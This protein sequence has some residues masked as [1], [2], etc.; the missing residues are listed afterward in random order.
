M[1][2]EVYM[3]SCLISCYN[4]HL[5]LRTIS[6]VLTEWLPYEGL[7]VGSEGVQ[8]EGSH[9]GRALL[10]GFLHCRQLPMTQALS[11]QEILIGLENSL[12]SII[13]RCHPI[14]ARKDLDYSAK[15]SVTYYDVLLP[16]Q[17]H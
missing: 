7:K 1:L 6:S 8:R 4:T 16:P 14:S 3:M 9:V 10:L 2:C 5:S 12:G 15:F 11:R 13:L 17:I